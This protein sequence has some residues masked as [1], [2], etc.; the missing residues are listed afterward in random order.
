[1]QKDNTALK[2][3]I[4]SVVPMSEEI[5]S[6]FANQFQPRTLE[7]GE[8]LIRENKV[9]KETYFLQDGVIRSFI[10]SSEGEEVTTELFSAVCIVNNF[11][12]FFKQVPCPENYQ[13]LTPCAIWCLSFDQM[14]QN[15][16]GQRPEFR[17]F[18]RTMLVTHY[19]KLQSRMIGLI[20][21]SAEARYLRLLEQHPDI[22]Q[23][24]PLKIIASNLG[25]TDSSLSRIR[26]EISRK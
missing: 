14:Q 17:E 9:S 6:A 11:L 10:T 22:F 16:H 12:S 15:F 7:K 23:H 25:I 24:V 1:M 20:K 8:F 5:A 3:Y 19:S 4:Q 13:A 26:K 2:N 18:G 21:D